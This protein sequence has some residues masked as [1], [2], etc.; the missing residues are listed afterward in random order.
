MRALR[1]VFRNEGEDIFAYMD[2]INELAV[3]LETV[4][5]THIKWFT[6]KNPYGCWICDICYAWK[7]YRQEV[8]KELE[9]ISKERNNYIR[10]KT[11]LDLL[12]D[13]VDDQKAIKSGVNTDEPGE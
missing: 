11:P 6:H 3:H 5:T 2:R 9:I 1:D 7:I 10:A 13:I 8:V 4:A 12:T